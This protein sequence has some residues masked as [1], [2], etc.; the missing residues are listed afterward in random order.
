MPAGLD[1]WPAAHLRLGRGAERS[2]RTTAKPLDEIGRTACR[3]RKSNL[4]SARKKRKVRRIDQQTA[5]HAVNI[6]VTEWETC[7]PL[8][9]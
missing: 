4:N 8:Q 2:A 3:K 5:I 1:R 6:Q 9:A 7:P